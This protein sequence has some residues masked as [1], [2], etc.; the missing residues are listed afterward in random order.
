VRVIAAFA[1]LV[2]CGGKPPPAA[3]SDFPA[4]PEPAW[5]TTYKQRAADGCGCKDAACLDQIHAELARIEAEHGGMD[6]APPGVQAAHGQFDGC[7]RERTKDPARDLDYLATH[8]CD[9]TDAACFAHWRL[10]AM[11]L[12]D[13]YDV[14]DLDE[15]A[16]SS[17][18]GAASL[19]RARTCIAA[20][21][22]GGEDLLA[23]VD[24]ATQAMC[25]CE[26]VGCATT[27][28]KE[29]SD[30][31]A[32]Y[33]EVDGLEVVQPRL[34]ELQPRYCRCLGDLVAKEVA[35]SLDPFPAATKIDVTMNCK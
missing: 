22:I 15:L 5:A 19:A 34:D 27:V 6:D 9:C 12:T 29:R 11:H 28:M 18:G 24:K 21:T 7:W 10:D 4:M 1:V 16:K 32:K 35:E 26:N 25:K 31:L 3:T 17:A 30:A 13:K 20:V 8:A 2:G 14:A 23:I 33:V